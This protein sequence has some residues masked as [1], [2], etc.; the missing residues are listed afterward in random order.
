M[1]YTEIYKLSPAANTEISILQ[2]QNGMYKYRVTKNGTTTESKKFKVQRPED[3][4]I[5]AR[6][7]A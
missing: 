2:G 6:R 5:W 1:T 3:A 4:V 7:N